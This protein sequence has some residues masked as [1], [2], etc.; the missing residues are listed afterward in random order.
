MRGGEWAQALLQVLET[1]PEDAWAWM[2]QHGECLKVDPY[3]RAGLLEV[4]GRSCF[5]K[6]YRPR[7]GVQATVFRTRWGRPLRNYEAAGRL[8][9]AGIAVPE[10]LACLRLPGAVLLLSEGLPGGDNLHQWWRSGERGERGRRVLR[11]VGELLAKVHAAGFAHG[12]CKWHNLLLYREQIF[13]VDL[14]SARRASRGDRAQGRDLARFT[15]NAEELAL[16][17]ADYAAFLDSYI[18]CIGV[19]ERQLMETMLPQLDKL[20]ARHLLQYGERGRRLV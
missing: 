13:L 14:D 10:P 17:R 11:A 8:S 2:E 4:Q 9:A 19:S 7:T 18:S 20:R 3:T 1:P 12:D 15:L 5:L 16:E 6:L